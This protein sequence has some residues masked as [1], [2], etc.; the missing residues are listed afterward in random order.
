M[1][2]VFACEVAYKYSYSNLRKFNKGKYQI[3]PM[4][5][6]NPD[7]SNPQLIG[8]R[9]AVPLYPKSPWWQL[10]PTKQLNQIQTMCPSLTT[11]NLQCAIVTLWAKSRA[12]DECSAVLTLLKVNEF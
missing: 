6:N 2:K 11:T 10:Y 1:K 9:S 3:M 7:M 12:W 8:Y 4:G 5:W